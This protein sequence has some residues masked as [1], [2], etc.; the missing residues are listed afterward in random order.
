MTT[1]EEVVD[2]AN[3]EIV[4]QMNMQHDAERGNAGIK[5]TQPPPEHDEYRHHVEQTFGRYDAVV[6]ECEQL[7][8]D[9]ERAVHGLEIANTKIT[10]LEDEAASLRS[11]NETLRMECVHAIASRAP[12]ESVLCS[13]QAMLREHGV[14]QTPMIKVT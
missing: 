13:I 1:R 14:Q 8:R 11:T 5:F 7:R 9:L 3:M 6:K 2:A 10:M 12:L 4:R